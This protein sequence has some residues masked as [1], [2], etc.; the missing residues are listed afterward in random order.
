MLRG[1][2][3]R[4]TILYILV[5]LGLVTMV[6]GGTYYFLDRY[7][8]QV[9]DLSLQHKMAFQFRVL[10]LPIPSELQAADKT[11]YGT[12]S[13]AQGLIKPVK[14]AVIETTGEPDGETGKDEPEDNET[15]PLYEMDDAYDA[16]LTSIFVFPVDQN[17][18]LVFDPNTFP[19]PIL[20]NLEAVKSAHK[21]GLDWR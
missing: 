13:S 3:F 6:G 8:K 12:R 4:L 14:T 17:G 10:G 9:T 20:P 15:Q 16:E 7:F 2:R 1:L 21:I 18:V 19:T 11:W 5:A